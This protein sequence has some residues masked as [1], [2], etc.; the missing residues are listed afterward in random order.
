MDITLLKHTDPGDLEAEF[1]FFFGEWYPIPKKGLTSF[2][3]IDY[4][5]LFLLK[6]IKMYF[7]RIEILSLV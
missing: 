1:G 6:L 5:N 3:N 7:T 2:Q 4:M